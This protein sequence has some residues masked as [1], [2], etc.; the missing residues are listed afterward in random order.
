VRRKDSFQGKKRRGKTV[1]A[2]D[3]FPCVRARGVFLCQDDSPSSTARGLLHNILRQQAHNKGHNNACVRVYGLQRGWGSDED[4]RRA[5]GYAAN[6]AHRTWIPATY[7]WVHGLRRARPARGPLMTQLW[8]SGQLLG[9]ARSST[10]LCP[11]PRMP[12]RRCSTGG[13]STFDE[14]T[15]FATKR[16]IS[17]RFWK[18]SHLATAPLSTFLS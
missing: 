1:G 7:K 13:L 6:F 4:R 12:S 16:P 11:Q 8:A 3:G 18:H 10:P 9:R 14:M 15:G 17:G 2:I 5:L